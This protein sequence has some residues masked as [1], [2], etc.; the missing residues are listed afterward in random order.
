MIILAWDGGSPSAI[1]DA[2]VFKKVLSIFITAAVMKLGQGLL[3]LYVVSF[4]IS[5]C[6]YVKLGQAFEHLYCLWRCCYVHGLKFNSVPSEIYRS[7]RC[8]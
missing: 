7:V 5:L 6:L 4:F 8:P 3:C 1:F 2:E